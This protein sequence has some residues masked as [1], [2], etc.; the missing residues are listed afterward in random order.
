MAQVQGIDMS[1]PELLAKTDAQMITSLGVV[2]YFRYI[3]LTALG[4]G[5]GDRV[6]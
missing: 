4:R 3:V 1:R 5:A 2:D 6:R